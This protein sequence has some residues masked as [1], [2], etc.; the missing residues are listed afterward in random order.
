MAIIQSAASTDLATVDPTMKAVHLVLKPDELI[1]AYQ[2]S[3]TSGAMT[4]IA[5]A[6]GLII[7][8]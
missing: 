4:A 5:A 8:S 1:G 2:L 3:A 7:P 6:N